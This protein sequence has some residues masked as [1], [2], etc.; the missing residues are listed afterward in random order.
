MLDPAATNY[1]YSVSRWLSGT[2]VVVAAVDSHGSSA[3]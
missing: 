2:T 3:A 1:D